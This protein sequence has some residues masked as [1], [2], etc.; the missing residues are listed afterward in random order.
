MSYEH[1]PAG[2]ICESVTPWTVV[3]AS[4]FDAPASLS[5]LAGWHPSPFSAARGVTAI[6]VDATLC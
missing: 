5:R 1:E 4:F 6:C 2:P 3:P